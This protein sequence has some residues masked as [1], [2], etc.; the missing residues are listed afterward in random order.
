[1]I[2]AQASLW[3]QPWWVFLIQGLAVWLYLANVPGLQPVHHIDTRG[4]L[5][6]L[7]GESLRQDLSSHR[8]WGYPLFLRAVAA[9]PGGPAMAGH[10]QLGFFLFAVGALGVAAGRYLGSGWKGVMF[11]SPLFYCPL[12]SGYAAALRPELPAAA[13]AVLSLAALLTLTLHPHRVWAWTALVLCLALTYHTRPSYL[14]LLAWVP[15]AGVALRAALRPEGGRRALLR[16]TVGLALAA[17]VPFLL[18][19]SLRLAVIGQFGLVSFGSVNWIGIT[20]S[21]LTPEMVPDL[22]RRDR[23]L[24]RQLLA[25]KAE[26]GLAPSYDFK[27]L[28]HEYNQVVFDSALA[29]IRRDPKRP[30]QDPRAQWLYANERFTALSWSIVKARPGRYLRWLV[31]ASWFTVV[32]LARAPW[33]LLPALACLASLVVAWRRGGASLDLRTRMLAA[34]ALAYAPLALALVLAVET[35]LDRYL[36]AGVLFVPGALLA[37]AFDVVREERPA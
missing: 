15:L 12:V 8:T 14:F 7:D 16:W 20:G 17:W 4:Y 32:K 13:W 19:S 24:A 28:R 11:A 2:G 36:F 25:R 27:R 31:D 5:V 34:T 3:R 33:T 30:K 10:F 22:P 26:L 29:A 6:A 37:V 18:W 1:M 23:P 21:L 35:P 9:L